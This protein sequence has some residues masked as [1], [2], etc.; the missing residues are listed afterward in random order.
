MCYRSCDWIK[1]VF[2]QF[3]SMNWHPWFI[4]LGL[5]ISLLVCISHAVFPGF[6]LFGTVFEAD[7]W[8]LIENLMQKCISPVRY[9]SLPKIKLH[10]SDSETSMIPLENTIS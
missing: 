3:S 8:K 9:S 1:I 6:V 7:Y 4:M 2:T 10:S 5:G